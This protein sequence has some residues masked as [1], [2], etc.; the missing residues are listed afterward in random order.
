MFQLNFVAN[1]L[2]REVGKSLS[3]L[4]C[5]LLEGIIFIIGVTP[6]H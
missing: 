6:D 4:M 2:K 5:K 3:L 1:L